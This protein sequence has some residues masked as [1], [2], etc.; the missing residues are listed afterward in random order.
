MTE[1][2]RAQ[3]RPATYEKSEWS[4]ALFIERYNGGPMDCEYLRRGAEQ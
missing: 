1:G 3:Q 2:W 4:R